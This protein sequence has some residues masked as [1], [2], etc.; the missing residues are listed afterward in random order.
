MAERRLPRS[1]ETISDLEVWMWKKLVGRLAQPSRRSPVAFSY[2]DS[3]LANGISISPLSLPL[4]AGVHIPASRQ[5][6]G[7]FGVF[8]DSLPDDWGRKL[9]D[10]MLVREG[11]DPAT[12][13]PLARL[14]LVGDAG[15]GALE[16]RPASKLGQPEAI[17]DFD[18]AFGQ[19]LAVIDDEPA[20][21]LDALY[22]QGG[23]SG[24]ARPK[25]MVEFEGAPWIVKFPLSSDEPNEG[26]EEFRF[27]R[28]AK[29]C[30]I[31][32]PEV[33]LLPSRLCGGFFAVRRFDRTP[34]NQ[35]AFAKT[36]MASAAA[37]LEADP[38]DDAV[39]YRDLM[40][41]TLTLTRNASDCEQLFRLMCFNV[42][43]G[44]CDDHVRNF[45]FLC[46]PDGSWR[47]SPAYDLTPNPGFF[48]EHS[49]LVNGKGSGIS[50]VDLFA[51]ASVGNV[52]T[53]KSNK[54]LAAMRETLRKLDIVTM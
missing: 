41:L 48:G 18:D 25:L 45:S 22:A 28:A 7:L 47:L 10:R 50:D 40:K 12:V 34:T 4:D 36:H 20:D 32:M 27:A 19:A 51:V 39:D 35:G 9:V 11:F 5:P 53:A 16:Y 30:G 15:L 37:L 44:N 38:F 2:D 21:M 42:L 24:G 3:W 49:I 26:C 8:R 6:G 54:I 14:A 46:D 52:S 17:L 29:A 1:L 43:A 13:T 23:S 33:A 31:N